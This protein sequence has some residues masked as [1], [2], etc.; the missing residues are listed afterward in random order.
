ARWHLHHRGCAAPGRHRAAHPLS[1]RDCHR[2][3]C[4]ARRLQQARGHPW[5]PAMSVGV[6]FVS[7]GGS[8][9]ARALRS[10]RRTEPS[11][12]VHIVFNTSANS[13]ARNAETHPPAT[14][15]R[16]PN[17]LVRC[18]TNS[19]Y[20][21]GSFNA[22][23]RWL[24]DLGY[25]HACV[26]QD[27]TIFSPLAEHRFHLSEWFPRIESDPDLASASGLSLAFMEALV[28]TGNSS[29]WHRS[30]EE[31]D[32]VDLESEPLWRRLCPGPDARPALYFGSPGSD[33]GVVLSVWFVKY[34]V[35][36]RTVSMSR[37]GPTGFIIPIRVWDALGGF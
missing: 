17:V 11:L 6:A 7:T 21:N 2:R 25:S 8:K 29:C 16:E 23:V 34:F 22:A 3:G 14:F 20:V 10:L 24:Q 19:G 13:W 5:E 37:L 18:I 15:E 12:P 9:V 26:L 33:E 36:E 27:D 28:R 32:V 35:T 1:L 30:P 31:W 4:R